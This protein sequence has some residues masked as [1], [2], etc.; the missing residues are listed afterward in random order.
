VGWGARSRWECGGVDWARDCCCCADGVWRGADTVSAV[1]A[2]SSVAQVDA[3]VGAGASCVGSVDGVGLY[4]G[5]GGDI[6]SEILP[7]GG[8]GGGFG[9]DAAYAVSLSADSADG[10]WCARGVGRGELCLG[11]IAVCRDGVAGGGGCA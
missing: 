3:V 10:V 7:R 11:Y 8:G 1:C 5:R 4:W 2:G 9:D 6:D